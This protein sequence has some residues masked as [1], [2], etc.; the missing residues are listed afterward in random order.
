MRIVSPENHEF[1]RL[2]VRTMK[3]KVKCVFKFIM[4]TCAEKEL[5]LSEELRVRMKEMDK[6]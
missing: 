3:E 6:M 2:E 1:I 5:I 4:V